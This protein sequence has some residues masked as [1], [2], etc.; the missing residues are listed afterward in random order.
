MCDGYGSFL[1]VRFLL[2]LNATRVGWGV[3]GAVV[4]P[5]AGR[6]AAGGGSMLGSGT[7]LLHLRVCQNC[8]CGMSPVAS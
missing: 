3:A 4:L 6:G 7:R 2:R 1:Y 8:A 5:A